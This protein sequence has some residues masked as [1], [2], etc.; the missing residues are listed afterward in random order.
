MKP[1]PRPVAD[2]THVVPF[3]GEYYE[4]KPDVQHLCKNLIYPVPDPALP[5]LGV[6][7]TSMVHGGVGCGPNAVLAFKREGYGRFSFSPRFVD[8]DD[9]GALDV[10]SLWLTRLALS[11]M[12]GGDRLQLVQTRDRIL[13]SLHRGLSAALYIAP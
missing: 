12:A 3:R 9:D 11:R 2:G 4:L 5:F 6:H 8:M 1:R 7:F 13:D 10:R